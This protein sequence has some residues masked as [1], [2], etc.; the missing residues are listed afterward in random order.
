MSSVLHTIVYIEVG[1]IL[2]LIIA[3]IVI[4][5]YNEFKRR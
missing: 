3:A 1:V 4:A 2:L 5:V